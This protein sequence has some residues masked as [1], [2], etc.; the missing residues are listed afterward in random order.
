M[1]S[2]L[3]ASTSSLWEVSYTLIRFGAIAHVT[4]EYGVNMTTC[5]GPS[6][7]PT[8]KQDGDNVNTCYL[9][10]I[11]MVIALR[12]ISIYFTIGAYRHVQ[13]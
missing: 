1:F 13:L 5:V 8:M 6:M 10:Y 4:T 12:L 11:H 2:R 9:L 3:L 7:I